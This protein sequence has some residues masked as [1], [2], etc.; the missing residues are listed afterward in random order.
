LAGSLLADR[1]AF[2][3]VSDFVGALEQLLIIVK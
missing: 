1:V 3:F 2:L